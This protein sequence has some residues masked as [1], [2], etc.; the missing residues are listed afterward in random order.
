MLA[1][2]VPVTKNA[3]PVCIHPPAEGIWS[4]QVHRDESTGVVSREQK[5][6][7]WLMC[8]WKAF[9]VMG[10]VRTCTAT[11]NIKHCLAAPS[12]IINA[13]SIMYIILQWQI[14]N[15]KGRDRNLS[16]YVKSLSLQVVTVVLNL[17]LT[18]Q[19]RDFPSFVEKAEA[20]MYLDDDSLL[21]DSG[22]FW[23]AQF[24]HRPIRL[25]CF[26]VFETR[27]PGLASNS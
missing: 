11:E 13:F 10:S 17:Y 16:F 2:K 1:E 7:T 8:R 9:Q 27:S 6:G 20:E 15:A 14:F 4:G 12:R 22:Q 19:W 23:L 26:F 5:A 21:C 25:F 3:S 18:V 24:H